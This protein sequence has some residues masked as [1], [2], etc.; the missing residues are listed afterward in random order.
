MEFKVG[1]KVTIKTDLEVG[2]I[3]GEESVVYS[4]EE[5][6]GKTSEIVRVI[7]EGVYRLK[8]I[9]FNWSEEM[10]DK[11]VISE[12]SSSETLFER[13][14]ATPCSCVSVPVSVVSSIETNAKPEP[15]TKDLEIKE[16]QYSE[17]RQYF[18]ETNLTT[19]D[20]KSDYFKIPAKSQRVIWSDKATIVIL[21]DGTKGVARCCPEDKHNKLKGLKIAYLRARI[22]S[23]QKELKELTK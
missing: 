1:D 12:D 17:M 10:L 19:G 14:S 8:G 7:F 21:D 4:M 18:T 16:F 6:F 2:K 9:E 15:K 5:D 20:F 3:Y 13:F 22:K 23:M 11:A